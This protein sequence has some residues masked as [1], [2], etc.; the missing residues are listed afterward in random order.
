MSTEFIS[1][2]FAVYGFNSGHFLPLNHRSPFDIVLA[3]DTRP[4][5]RALF[6]QFPHCPSILNSADELLKGIL[7]STHSSTI[8]GYFIHAHRF[9]EHKTEQTFWGVQSAI[10]RVLR[11][12]QGLQV[13]WVFIHPSC[14]MALAPRLSPCS[15]THWLDGFYNTSLLPGP[16]QL[17]C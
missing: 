16:R 7:S 8:H 13:F 14:D 9:Q 10:V 15:I 12:K 3:A 11:S 2:S 4:S 5:D 17:C 6:K 1:Y